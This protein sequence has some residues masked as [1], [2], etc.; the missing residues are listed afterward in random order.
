MERRLD[1][2]E[3]E[4]EAFDLGRGRTLADEINDLASNT[5][6]EAELNELKS[7]L[8]KGRAPSSEV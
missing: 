1:A 5:A 3:S 6:V 8:G 2:A 4:V 7:K